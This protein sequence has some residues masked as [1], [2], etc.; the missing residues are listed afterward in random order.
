MHGRGGTYTAQPTLADTLVDALHEMAH[1]KSSQV[2]EAASG[3]PLLNKQLFE[4]LST[5]TFLPKLKSLEL[6]W[7]EDCQP[8]REL[9][10]ALSARADGR[11]SSVV[12]GI[13]NGGNLGPDVLVCLRGLRQKNVRA[14]RW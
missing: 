3:L 14:T 9:L 10:S 6:V 7:A 13:R 11:L 5:D 4:Q 1:L 12:L 2:I 8:D